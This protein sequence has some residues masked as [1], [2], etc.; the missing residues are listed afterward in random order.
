MK[1]VAVSEA[2]T[3][4]CPFARVY[5]DTRGMDDTVATTAANRFNTAAPPPGARCIASQC[6]AWCGNGD[7]T[8]RCG[9][10]PLTHPR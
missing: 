9:L 1:A 10:V 7:G 2:L 8:G 5:M 6:M 4:W 3:R